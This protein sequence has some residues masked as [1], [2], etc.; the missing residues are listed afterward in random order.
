M[1]NNY[2]KKF[3]VLLTSLVNA[4]SHTKCVSLSHKRHEIQP[5]LTNLHPNE[6]NQELHYYSFAVKLVRY[7]G[8][9]NTLNDLSTK[10]FLPNKTGDLNIHIFSIIT[11]INDSKILIKHT[12]CECKCIFDGRKCNSDKMWKN[13][14]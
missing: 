14:K 6:Y 8:S 9:C 5:T 7:V 10:E 4:S 2:Q 1:F 12:S 13:Y 11:G 3:I